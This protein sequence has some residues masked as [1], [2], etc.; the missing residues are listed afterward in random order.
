MPNIV[1]DVPKMLKPA[2]DAAVDWL[3]QSRGTKFTLTG[4]ADP[5]QI[6]EE[7]TEK[8]MDLGLILCDEDTCVRE[9]VRIQMKNG[10]YTF[11]TI[12]EGPT[13]VPSHLDPPVGIRKDWIEHKLAK[14]RFIVLL[15]YRGLW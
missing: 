12:N 9:D 7:I 2:A 14:H 8:P 11:T 1:E 6:L 10:S 15:F 4:V 3:N 5:P 13:Q